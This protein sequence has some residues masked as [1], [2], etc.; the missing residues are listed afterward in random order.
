MQVRRALHKAGFRYSL[1]DRKLPGQPDLIFASRKAIVFIHGCFWHRHEGCKRAT[2]PSANAAFWREKLDKNAMRDA[3]CSAQ[4]EL[5]GWSVHV[6]WE[7][8]IRDG[9]YWVPL[10][11]FLQGR[12]G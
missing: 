1:H 5:L 10:F 2:T 12:R 6:V 3:V 8:E 4:L 7:C 9:S 11:E